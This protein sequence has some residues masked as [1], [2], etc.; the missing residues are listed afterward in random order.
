MVSSFSQVSGG[1]ATLIPESGRETPGSRSPIPGHL[2][3]KQSGVGAAGH[4]EA[5]P[6]DEDQ[7]RQQDKKGRSLGEIVKSL[8][9]GKAEDDAVQKPSASRRRSAARLLRTTGREARGTELH[10]GPGDE[11]DQ[12]QKR[13]RQRWRRAEL[14]VFSRAEEFFRHFS[15]TALPPPDASSRLLFISLS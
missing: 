14:S 11:E 2:G 3:Q 5:V 13:M 9:L 1:S 6:A 15:S 12:G 10:R 8:G 7:V 4:N